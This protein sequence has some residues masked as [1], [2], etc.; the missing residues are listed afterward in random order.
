MR[1]LTVKRCGRPMKGARDEAKFTLVRHRMH[2]LAEGKAAIPPYQEN[3]GGI[4][5]ASSC[6]EAGHCEPSAVNW[7]QISAA[8]V[9]GVPDF[10][11]AKR[12]SCWAFG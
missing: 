9:S 1:D 12:N 11:S 7:R 6:E 3:V 8:A 4:I 10:E 5:V 2:G